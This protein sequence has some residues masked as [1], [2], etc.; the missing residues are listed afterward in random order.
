LYESK[1]IN[2]TAYIKGF[3]AYLIMEKSLSKHSI[4]AYLRDVEKFYQYLDLHKIHLMPENV[5][6]KHVESFI[7]YLSD[8]GLSE[9]SSARILSGIKA[10]YKY[11][12]IE[13]LINDDPTELIN[14]PKL[15]RYLPDVLSVEEVEAIMNAIDMSEET[16]HRN[17]AILE[18][19]YAC[20][21]R[22]SELVGLKLSHYYPDQG[23]L[24]VLGKNNKER[25]IPIG[26][27]AIKCI[28]IYLNEVRSKVEKIK[29][30]DEDILFL[31]RR[32]A[33]LT[34]VMI[35]HIIK[36]LTLKSGIKKSVSPH[37]F[38]HSFATH[39]VEMGADLRAVQ[40]MLGHESIITTEIYTHVNTE[41]LRK[42]IMDFHPLNKR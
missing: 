2:W 40:E 7:M 26:S 29:T 9:K 19:L 17:R 42:T 34:R 5:K 4:E 32:G 1:A 15:T 39:L 11:L 27:S 12:L 13:D 20:G 18:T 28:N 22:V 21:L 24:K 14:G 25:L 36:D 8:L 10:F 38:R 33:R 6:L 3:E 31:N 35:F 23:F 41:Y 37:T 16:A 30:L